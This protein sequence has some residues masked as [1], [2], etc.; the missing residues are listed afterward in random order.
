MSLPY[1]VEHEH[2]LQAIQE[3]DR[4]GPDSI[5]VRRRIRKYA[6]REGKGEYPPKYLICLAHKFV[7]DRL[8][9]G[10][11]SGGDE[12]NT[13]IIAR[14]LHVWDIS[15][16]KAKEVG[17]EPVSSDE[18]SAFPEGKAIYRRH[19]SL[20]RDKGIV[21]LAKKK[22]FQEKGEFSCDVCA[23]SFARAYGNLG[24]GF[25]EAHHTVPVSQMKAKRKTKITEIALVCSNC[26]RMLHL[27]Y[28]ITIEGLQK[29]ITLSV[30][31][32]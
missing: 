5:P 6:V 19:K 14:G 1:D 12:A 23:F 24:I 11:F 16:A 28:P 25:I 21:R 32:P 18:E 31:A 22:R 10:V 8:F 7:D 13:F 26:H 30:P 20:E 15:G 27:W 17:L 9:E 3:I 2:I 4:V 29:K